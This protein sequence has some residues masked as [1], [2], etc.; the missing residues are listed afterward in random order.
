MSMKTLESAILN[1]AKLATN[2]PKL[3]NKHLLE[4]STSEAAV[5]KNL[6]PTDVILELPDPGVW[7]AVDESDV[8]FPAAE[9]A[10]LR[11]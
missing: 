6:Q 3:R 10:R 2:N 5:R 9:I 4:W 11:A 1:A 7:I 8:R